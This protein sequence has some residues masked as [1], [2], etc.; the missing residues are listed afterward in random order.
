MDENNDEFES[1]LAECGATKDSVGVST[2]NAVG[3]SPSTVN[4]STVDASI[5]DASTVDVSTVDASIVDA[6]TVDASTVDASTVNASTVDASTVNAS[7]VDA[8]T[9]DAS[10]VDPSANADMG[11]LHSNIQCPED[12]IFSGMDF[13][14]GSSYYCYCTTMLSGVHGRRVLIPAGAVTEPHLRL[15]VCLD[16]SPFVM[17]VR[18]LISPEEFI[19]LVRELLCEDAGPGAEVALLLLSSIYAMGECSSLVWSRWV[20]I[21]L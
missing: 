9:V 8:N 3:A 18:R 4:A 20:Y 6:S 1:N 7:T 17:L 5:V 19:E 10:T 2:A 15:R 11:A 14:G 16:H 21:N 13:S 12:C